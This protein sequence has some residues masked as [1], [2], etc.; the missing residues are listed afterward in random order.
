MFL[1]GQDTPTPFV[2]MGNYGVFTLG[3]VWKH[4]ITLGRLLRLIGNYRQA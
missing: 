1:H 3:V 2:W 4:I